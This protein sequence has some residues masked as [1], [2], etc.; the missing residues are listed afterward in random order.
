MAKEPQELKWIEELLPEE[1]YRR[2]SMFGGFAYYLAE[3]MVLATFESTGNRTYKN[4]KYPYEIWNGCMFPVEKEHQEKALQRFP[5]LISH[6]VLPKWLYLPLETESFEELATEVVTQAIKPMGYW[7]SIPKPKSKKKKSKESSPDLDKIDTRTPRMFSDEPPEQIL[8]TAQKISDL[9]N[10]GI[11]AQ[12]EFH[13]AGIK[14]VAQFTKL[15]WKKSLLKLAKSNPKNRHSVFA[16]A[17]IG[18]LNN[19]DWTAIS[20]EEKA[21][22]RDFVKSIPRP[23][24]KPPAKAYSKRVR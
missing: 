17:L 13:K 4:K 2:K 6:P 7:G 12:Q 1:E 22:A 15:G 14:T 23:K 10:L 8:K 18:A 3:K 5:F 19:K 20:E 16:Y 9:K 21:E 11:K 24:T